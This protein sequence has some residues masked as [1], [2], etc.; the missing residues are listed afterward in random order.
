M[1]S[2]ADQV[3]H[4]ATVCTQFLSTQ[5]TVVH[6]LCPAAAAVSLRPAGSLHVGQCECENKVSKIEMY[7]KSMNSNYRKTPSQSVCFE[8][9]DVSFSVVMWWWP[10]LH[11]CCVWV[12]VVV[13]MC[14]T[15]TLCLSVHT[16]KRGKGRWAGPCYVTLWCHPGIIA[17][18]F[19]REVFRAMLTVTYRTQ[20]TKT[21]GGKH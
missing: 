8:Q 7:N 20:A 19:K 10:V 21:L 6:T 12:V 5:R 17:S 2:Y 1:S 18:G 3:Q 14:C 16:Y 13:V 15:L 9:Q 4:S 11:P